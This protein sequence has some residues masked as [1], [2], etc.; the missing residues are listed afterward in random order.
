MWLVVLLVALL[1]AW[2]IP[3]L[4]ARGA[5]QLSPTVIT[6]QNDYIDATPKSSDWIPSPE[7]PPRPTYSAPSGG[8][9]IRND[10]PIPSK[11]DA[12]ALIVYWCEFYNVD[13][14]RCLRVSYCE[15]GWYSQAKNKT[16]SAAGLYQ[17]IRST[18]NSTAL[19]MGKEWTYETHVFSAEANAQAGAY[20]A[21]QTGWS[22][23]EC[24]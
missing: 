18:F 9:K 19:K 14:D 17:F 7:V 24:K 13:I 1:L 2:S 21:S 11:E 22:P 15:S 8:T 5:P 3:K 6:T 20:L 16:S 23:W 10:W 4:T 12:R